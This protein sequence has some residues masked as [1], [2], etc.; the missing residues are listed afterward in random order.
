MPE[1]S[2]YQVK[3]G[4]FSWFEPVKMFRLA[5]LGK[6]VRFDPNLDPNLI[7]LQV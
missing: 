7:I 2:V 5:E 1:N 3:P 6:N 4:C